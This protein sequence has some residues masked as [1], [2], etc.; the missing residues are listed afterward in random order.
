[1]NS[2][3]SVRSESRV[4]TKVILGERLAKLRGIRGLKLGLEAYEYAGAVRDGGL[5]V[6][7]MNEGEELALHFAASMWIEFLDLRSAEDIRGARVARAVGF[8]AGR[9]RNSSIDEDSS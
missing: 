3:W 6:L 7:R 9:E 4:G 1:M 8:T 2:L 5:P